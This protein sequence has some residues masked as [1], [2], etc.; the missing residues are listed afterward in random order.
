MSFYIMLIIMLVSGVI[1]GIVFYL[2]PE[3]KNEDGK[4]K[5][6]KYECII[7]G[8]GATLLVPLFLEIAQS[9]LMDDIRFKL[10]FVSKD[11]PACNDT[12]KITRYTDTAHVIFKSDTLLVKQKDT[13][14]SGTENE[15]GKNYLLWAAYCMLAAAAGAKF[16]NMLIKS[17]VKDDV[18]ALK[19]ENMKL[20]EEKRMTDLQNKA[21]ATQ[22]EKQIRL[23][24]TTS[25]FGQIVAKK[26]DSSAP[27]V[28]GPI[29]HLDDPQKGR[30]GGKQENNFRRLSAKVKSTN[31]PGLFSIGLMVE[32]TDELLHPLTDNVIFYLHDT[33]RPSV[34]AVDP[35]E[36]KAR[37]EINYSYGAFT[38][39]VVTDGGET[40]LELDLS[41]QTEFP[42][43]FREN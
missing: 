29:L 21:N 6:N 16:I 31:I 41:E 5:S 8:I 12:L 11:P 39:G 1:G 19:T 20:L 24:G 23:P 33:F 13:L 17:V 4:F 2:L 25:E 28:L 38:V 35:I 43:E 22:E 18:V 9:K 14:N 3:N 7:L 10:E 36:N 40:L 42:K 15:T 30:F 26:L 32:S 34:I 37:H 27:P